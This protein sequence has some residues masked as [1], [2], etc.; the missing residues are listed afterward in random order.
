M[1]NLGP[2]VPL[3]FPAFHPDWKMMD[4]ENT[5][6]E[7]LSRARR[8]ALKNGIRY[9]YTGNV[10]DP[11]GDT[12]LCHRCGEALIARDWYEMSVWNL[13]VGGNY[14]G[15]CPNC[16]TVLPGVFDG[17]PGDWGRKRMPVRIGAA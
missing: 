3:H 10:H 2:E 16:G 13:D 6:K 11:E 5:P 9:A 12:T 1:E 17:P 4:K 7:T 8:I 15:N 14:S